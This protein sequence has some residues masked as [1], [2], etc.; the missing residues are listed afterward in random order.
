MRSREAT[1][2]IMRA[3][4]HKDTKPELL[5]RR[6]LYSLG[7]RYRLHSR[8]VP[9]KPDLVF[10]S[11][12][13]AIFVHGCF[14]HGHGCA[15]DRQPRSR[16]SFWGPKLRRNRQRD[17]DVARLLRDLGWA[18]LTV[19]ECELSEPDLTRRLRTFLGRR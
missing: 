15:N 7:Y 11:R 14:W 19:W 4:R 1:Q 5:V 17:A 18:T 10:R 8:M 3:V 2:R 6:L 16:L 9:G 13:K 12:K